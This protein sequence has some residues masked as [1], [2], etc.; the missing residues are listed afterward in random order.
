M[1]DDTKTTTPARPPARRGPGGGGPFGG[2]GMPAEKSMNFLPSAK[3]LIRR[4]RPEWFGIIW[5]LLFAVASVAL[6]VIGPKLLGEGTN[7]IFEG[8]ISKSLPEGV[9]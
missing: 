9:T 5:V 3:R 2:M 8:A 7:L 4:L 6:S 1:S